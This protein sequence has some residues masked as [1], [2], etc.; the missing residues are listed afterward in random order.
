MKD[1][2]LTASCTP[3]YTVFAEIYDD[4]MNDIP[5]E[6]WTG[7]ICSILSEFGI[8]EGLVAELGCGTGTLTRALAQAGYDMIGIDNSESMLAIAR[9]Y[10]EIEAEDD[11][12]EVEADVDAEGKKQKTILYLDQDMRDLEFYGTVAACVSV[13]DSMNYLTKCE[14]LVSVLKN[15]NLYLEK[16][17][18]FIFDMKTRHTYKDVLGDSVQ[19]E[20]N[21]DSAIIW[22]NHFDEE[23]GIHTYDLTMFVGYEVGKEFLYEKYKETH[24]QRSYSYEEVRE[25]ISKAGM[26]LVRFIDADTL[27]E[28]TDTTERVYYIAKECYQKEKYYGE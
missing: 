9:E 3:A 11:I 8:N 20:E 13:C 28:P 14:D 27:G 12:D 4:Y 25:A 21:D 15:V 18:I 7:N 19:F 23:T 2:L 22:E 1:K 26:E 24:R 16:D 6:R 17:G 10:E 5:Y